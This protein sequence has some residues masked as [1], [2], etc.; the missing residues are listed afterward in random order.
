MSV[1]LYLS[2]H[3]SNTPTLFAKSPDIMHIMR[4]LDISLLAPRIVII[5]IYYFMNITINSV[6]EKTLEST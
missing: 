6:Y 1:H 4:S 5:I 3:C 2:L